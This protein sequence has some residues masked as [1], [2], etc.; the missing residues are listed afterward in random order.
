MLGGADEAGHW[1]R[2]FSGQ[3]KKPAGLTPDERDVWL[4]LV[5]HA[6]EEGDQEV[7]DKLTALAADPEQF[8]KFMA[9]VE[10]ELDDE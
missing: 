4:D 1:L 5:A 7:I 8:R 6:K 10:A 2:A 9:E 3:P